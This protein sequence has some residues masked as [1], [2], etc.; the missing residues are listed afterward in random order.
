FG[1]SRNERET[2]SGRLHLPLLLILALPPRLAPAQAACGEHCGTDQGR[3]HRRR[4]RCVLRRASRRRSPTLVDGRAVIA[5]RRAAARGRT[6][7]GCCV[8]ARGCAA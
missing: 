8:T 1:V 7:T 3:N 2:T 4:L 5:R 6:A